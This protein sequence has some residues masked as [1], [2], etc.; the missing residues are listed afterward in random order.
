MIRVVSWNTGG[1][2]WWDACDPDV[3]VVLLQEARRPPSA[4]EFEMVPSVDD[5]W[6][7]AGLGRR[8]W[9]TVIAAPSGRVG[10]RPH[11]LAEE[12]DP[13]QAASS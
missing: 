13:L 5:E 10:L 11:P 7:T 4:P 6:R 3:D 2:D 8:N 9:A 12:Q 1:R